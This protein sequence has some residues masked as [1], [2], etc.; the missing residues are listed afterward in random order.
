VETYPSAFQ[1]STF[2]NQLEFSAQ[3]NANQ[4]EQFWPGGAGGAGGAGGVGGVA[5]GGIPGSPGIAGYAGGGG[6][7]LVIT[8]KDPPINI[9]IRAAAGSGGSNG[10]SSGTVII[11]KNEGI[12]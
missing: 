7:V 9:D 8:E 1:P 11:I 5:E 6:V 2:N 3:Q 4:P 12:Q 10:S